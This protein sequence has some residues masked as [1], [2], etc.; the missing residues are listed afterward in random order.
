MQSYRNILNYTKVRNAFLYNFNW[1]LSITPVAD[2]PDAQY[3][4]VMK[5]DLDD[6]VKLVRSH[7]VGQYRSLTQYNKS[8]IEENTDKETG[9]II[10][11]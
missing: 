10:Y 5:T 1:I 9:K 6:S 7:K 4:K 2:V 11:G 3:E 8:F